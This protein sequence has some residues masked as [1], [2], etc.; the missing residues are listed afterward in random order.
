MAFGESPH[1]CNNET[2]TTKVEKKTNQ[3]MAVRRY[4]VLVLSCAVAMT[5]VAVTY[6]L[7]VQSGNALPLVAVESADV[8]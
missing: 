2:G 3:K 8:G 1:R 6:A 4:L 5:F 7:A